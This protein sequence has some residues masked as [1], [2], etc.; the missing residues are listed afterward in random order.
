MKTITYDVLED[1]VKKK[2]DD[3][4]TCVILKKLYRGDWDK[5][6]DGIQI[7]ERNKCKEILR[8]YYN[9]LETNEAQLMFH[10]LLIKEG[11]SNFITKK[12]ADKQRTFSITF[13]E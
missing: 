6:L 11:W 5:Q 2:F 4:Y 10:L 12:L 1:D 8:S 9:N 3:A 13:K 7:A